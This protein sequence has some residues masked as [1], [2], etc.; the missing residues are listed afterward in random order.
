MADTQKTKK[1]LLLETGNYIYLYHTN[2]FLKLPVYPESIVDTLQSTFA[3]EQAIARS[4]PIF[5]YSNSGPRSIR[6]QFVLH[7][8]LVQ[9]VNANG[10][11]V[12]TTEVGEDYVDALIRNLQSIALPNY[13][14]ASKSVNPPMVA[15]RIGAGED[16]FIKGVVSGG[17]TVGYAP[18]ILSNGRYAL[19]TIEFTVYE[20]DP[21]DAETVSRLGSFRGFTRAFKD[22]FGVDT[23]IIG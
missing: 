5:T 12:I 15:V 23:E 7:R 22:G 9:E 11:D 16:I 19:V 21:Y 4:A 17:V 14:V 18:P 1:R 6:F 3:Q 13:T 8:D 20:I 2:K 10:L